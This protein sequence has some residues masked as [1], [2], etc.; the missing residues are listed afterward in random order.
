MNLRSTA[1]S[2]HCNCVSAKIVIVRTAHL[3]PS[4]FFLIFNLFLQDKK[5]GDYSNRSLNNERVL[6]G[7][8]AHDNKQ[9]WCS[10]KWSLLSEYIFVKERAHLVMVYA[11]CSHLN[12]DFVIMG[13]TLTTVQCTVFLEGIHHTGLFNSLKL[14]AV[15]ATTATTLNIF[16]ILSDR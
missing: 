5:V 9:F 6:L 15:E 2:F 1:A 10:K 11:S 13:V 12:S 8:C 16:L 3:P 7:N 14:G 4:S